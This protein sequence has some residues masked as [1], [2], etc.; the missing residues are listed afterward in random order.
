MV[1]AFSPDHSVLGW[2]WVKPDQ[3]RVSIPL[4]RSATLQGQLV[5][6]AS[7][8]PIVA[9]QIRTVTPVEKGRLLR[10]SFGVQ[11]ETDSG[12][13]FTLRGFLPG[14]PYWVQVGDRIAMDDRRSVPDLRTGF[15]SF[16]KVQKRGL[17]RSAKSTL[18][19]I[20]I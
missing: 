3:N 13:R 10:T 12:G 5:D 20:H 17:F 2:S 18:S 7:G 16:S 1:A 9:L 6:G 14:V 4:V 19:L 15:Q 8:R 11:V